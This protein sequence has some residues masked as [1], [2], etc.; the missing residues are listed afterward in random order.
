MHH[1]ADNTWVTQR[2]PLFCM[3]NS[4]GQVLTWKLTH[5]IKFASCS[6]V[7]ITHRMLKVFVVDMILWYALAHVLE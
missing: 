5:S 4:A 6:A 1:T 2:C 3:L 7:R